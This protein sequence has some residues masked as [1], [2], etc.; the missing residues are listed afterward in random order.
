MCSTL[1]IDK[2]ELQLINI[3][4]P[5]FKPLKVSTLPQ[6][7][8]CFINIPYTIIFVTIEYGGVN[9]SKYVY[10]LTLIALIVI[11]AIIFK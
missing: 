9:M 5:F 6:N 8:P 10:I 7:T 2:G 4:F 3:F 11:T 1:I